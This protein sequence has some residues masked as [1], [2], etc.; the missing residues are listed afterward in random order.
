MATNGFIFV[1]EVLKI[2]STYST[3]REAE[4]GI[5]KGETKTIHIEALD[6]VV[7]FI[8]LP[9]NQPNFKAY[10]ELELLL[11]KALAALASNDFA[12]EIQCVKLLT[13]L[14]KVSSRYYKKNV[15]QQSNE[16]DSKNSF[17]VRSPRTSKLHSLSA[18]FVAHPLFGSLCGP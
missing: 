5:V 17:Q 6:F 16:L 15:F 11:L 2:I 12:D 13:M 18:R 4:N 14:L 1:C 10:E 9:F 8:D 3:E 7:H